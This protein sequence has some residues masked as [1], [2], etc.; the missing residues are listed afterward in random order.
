[1]RSAY[2]A[3]GRRTTLLISYCSRFKRLYV[4]R[5][6]LVWIN[7]RVRAILSRC[8]SHC[9]WINSHCSCCC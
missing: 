2:S 1:M 4:S 9:V 3:S 6:R 7:C 8:S 5:K